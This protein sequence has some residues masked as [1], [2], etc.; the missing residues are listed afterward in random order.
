MSV[1][2]EQHSVPEE[3]RAMRPPT[4]SEIKM[5]QAR[6]GIDKRT[7]ARSIVEVIIADLSDRQGLSDAW[8]SIDDGIR[9]EIV[10]TWTD[11]VMRRL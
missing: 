5:E 9:K 11:N 8:Y 6:A 7:T 3:R 10:A 4:P 2:S 1:L